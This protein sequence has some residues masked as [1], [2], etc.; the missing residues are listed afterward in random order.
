MNFILCSEY[1]TFGMAVLEKKKK[2]IKQMC[3]FFVLVLTPSLLL[4]VQSA[5]ST[6]PMGIVCVWVHWSA[7]SWITAGTTAMRRTAPSSPSTLRR[8]SSTV[9]TVRCHPTSVPFLFYLTHTATG[10]HYLTR[11]CTYMTRTF[12]L[13]RFCK[14]TF[15]WYTIS[16]PG[17]TL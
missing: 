5:S 9:S 14:T 11:I 7:T 8:A 15:M 6:A 1:E 10:Q 4:T 12:F 2:I 17:R 13:A 16:L 3:L